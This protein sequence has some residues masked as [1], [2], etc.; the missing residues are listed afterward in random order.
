MMTLSLVG[1]N[2]EFKALHVYNVQVKKMKKIRSLMKLCGKLA[3]VL[4][5]MARSNEAYNPHKT[6][7]FQLAA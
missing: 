1:N 2:P 3:R 6:K 5:G 7:S 4:V